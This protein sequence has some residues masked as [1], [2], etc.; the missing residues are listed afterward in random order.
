MNMKTHV[1]MSTAHSNQPTKEV[2]SSIALLVS[3]VICTFAILGFQYFWYLPLINQSRQT[4]AVTESQPGIGA[5]PFAQFLP[6]NYS[7]GLCHDIADGRSIPAGTMCIIK[8][9]EIMQTYSAVK[10]WNYKDHYWMD[11]PGT[12]GAGERTLLDGNA[13]GGTTSSPVVL[14]CPWGCT[15]GYPF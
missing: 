1:V 12:G 5:G 4:I 2:I 3:V 6:E 14:S 7:G 9:G 10:I 15:L 11:P 13:L 8:P